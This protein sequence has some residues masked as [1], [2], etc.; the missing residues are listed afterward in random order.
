MA[1]RPVRPMSDEA[2]RS[3]NI[4]EIE[5]S[6]KINQK[7]LNNARIFSSREE[8]AKSLPK[9][10]KYMEVG[11]AWG[12]SVQMFLDATEAQSAD[13]VDL[14]NQDLKCWSWRKFESCQCNGFKH[15]L[16][17]TPE[18]HE[19]YI[20]DKFSS[21]KNVR[22]IKGDALRI[23]PDLKNTYDLIYIDVSNDRLLSRE[24]LRLCASLV[25]VGGVIGLNDYAIYD[26][27]IEDEPYGTFQTVN[28]FLYNNEDWEVDAIAL[29]NLG[30]Y[31][32]YL[33]RTAN[34]S[35]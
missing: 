5:D 31:D 16:L 23:L 20:I 7:Q 6:E 4:D 18:T 13:L 12:Y 19:Q 21:Y 3:M 17:Y 9:G 27:I 34:G 11:V 30:F 25:E 22:T 8:Y 15:E 35:K 14:Y 29:H 24:I 1:R 26:G 2:I 28:E 32:I 10:I 33:R